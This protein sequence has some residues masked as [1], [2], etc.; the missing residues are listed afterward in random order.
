MHHL[1]F[2]KV[3]ILG[4]VPGHLMGHTQ[5]GEQWTSS[6]HDQQQQGRCQEVNCSAV[7]QLK[8]WRS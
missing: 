5:Q 8:W 2:R 3:E 7:E 4:N 6:R 1:A